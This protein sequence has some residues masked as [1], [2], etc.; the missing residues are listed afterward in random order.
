MKK[1]ISK[2]VFLA[3]TAGVLISCD[4]EESLNSDNSVY[5]YKEG[6]YVVNEGEW[7]QNNGTLQFIDLINNTITDDIYYSQNK[8]MMGDLFQ[9]ICIY[10][11]KIYCTLTESSKVLVL[12]RDG[13]LVKNISMKNQEGQPLKP[14]YM[15][16]YD[17]NVYVTA[18]D[19]QVHKLDTA[20]LEITASAK[21]GSYPEALTI[22]NNKLFVNNA[23]YYGSG[24]TVSVID[25]NSFENIK[26][27]E[28]PLNP[29]N[30]SVTVNDE[31]YIVCCKL[32]GENG[33][34]ST[35]VKIDP[36][37]YKTSEI[38]TASKIA[39]RNNEIYIIYNDWYIENSLSYKVYN[40]SENKIIND[41]FINKDIASN[42]NSINVD[43]I[44]GNIY[45]AN[46]KEGGLGEVISFS[47]LGVV[48]SKY[49]TG[50]YTSKVA[51]AY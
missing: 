5:D 50:Y 33:E 28:V 32:Y 46:I 7:G 19:E 37:T 40:V 38:T 4:K 27:I 18:Y 35:L 47:Q 30:Q 43:P 3:M 42:P 21:V 9:D 15:K 39:A 16:S 45:V 49:N 48:L 36:K 29:Y 22:A 17:G 8:Q 14:R 1:N 44:N 23:G 31:V 2:F 34:A 10:G 20:S 24:N 12:D 11:S 6:A 51:F 25:L 26:T 41:K 13:K